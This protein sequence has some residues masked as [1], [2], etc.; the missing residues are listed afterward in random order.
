MARA[1]R[2]RLATWRQTAPSLPSKVMHWGVYPHPW[3]EI[4]PFRLE[5]DSRLAA[6]VP[7]GGHGVLRRLGYLMA[8][9]VG[10][11]RV[12]VDYVEA[13]QDAAGGAARS[14]DAD[15]VEHLPGELPLWFTDMKN[16]LLV[17]VGD[18]PS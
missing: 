17:L 6:G 1:W 16:L 11:N 7:P 5:L 2:G 3:G 14:D 9:A 18:C 8:M 12:A 10:V 13:N 15:E 4:G